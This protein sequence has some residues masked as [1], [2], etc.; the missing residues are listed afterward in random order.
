MEIEKDIIGEIFS[1]VLL[2]L[3]IESLQLTLDLVC[4]WKLSK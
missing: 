2:P 4:D 3:Y 1:K